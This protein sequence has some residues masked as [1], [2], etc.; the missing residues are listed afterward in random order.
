MHKDSTT[1]SMHTKVPSSEIVGKDDSGK[2][3]P[4]S[5]FSADSA[6]TVNDE[7]DLVTNL[8]KVKV[9]STENMESERCS[10]DEEQYRQPLLADC[11]EGSLVSVESANHSLPLHTKVPSA[12]SDI[13]E[14][15]NTRRANYKDVPL[16]AVMLRSMESANHLLHKKVPSTEINV[17]DNNANGESYEDAPLLNVNDEEVILEDVGSTD[18]KLVS[19]C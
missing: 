18:N 12:E 1:D 16:S 2:E 11:D 4:F 15:N 6:F 13:E 10:D 3:K 8:R 9:P 14:D 17:T 5:F 7:N 19:Y